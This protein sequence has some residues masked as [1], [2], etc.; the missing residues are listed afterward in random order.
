MYLG[1]YI[2]TYVHTDPDRHFVDPRALRIAH[3]QRQE[4]HA[5]DSVR[6]YV[7]ERDHIRS[8]VMRRRQE[9]RLFI[10][11]R[12]IAKHSHFHSTAELKLQSPLASSDRS[13]SGLDYW[14]RAITT[15]VLP[16]DLA[17]GRGLDI[18]MSSYVSV[19]VAFPS[20]HVQPN[21][22]LTPHHH[23]YT[24]MT[25]W[26][27]PPCSPTT[28]RRCPCSKSRRIWGTGATRRSSA[29]GRCRPLIPR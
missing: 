10:S 9:G 22:P 15:Q 23:N 26:P 27:P 28:A 20:L 16:A 12:L 1:T 18:T 29:C 2:H 17:A 3:P 11:T 21:T 4:H 24:N 19:C 8:V 13:A 6:V 25:A 7:S 5:A 14:N